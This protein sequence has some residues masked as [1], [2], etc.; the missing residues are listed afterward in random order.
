VLRLKHLAGD[1]V[2][3]EVASGDVLTVEFNAKDQSPGSA[4]LVG[5][6]SIVYEGEIDLEE[7]DHV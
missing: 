3:L 2:R 1:S 4:Y 6:A 7:L 5:P